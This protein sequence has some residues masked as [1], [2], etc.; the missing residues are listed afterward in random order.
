MNAQAF[1]LLDVDHQD[2]SHIQSP[3]MHPLHPL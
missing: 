1:E 2:T 3:R